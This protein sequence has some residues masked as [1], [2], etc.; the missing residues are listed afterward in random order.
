MVQLLALSTPSRLASPLHNNRLLNMEAIEVV[1]SV[2]AGQQQIVSHDGT[3]QYQATSDSTSVGTSACGL[4]ALNCARKLFGLSQDPHNDSCT[5]KT[6]L[7][8]V[9]DKDRCFLYRFLSRQ[10]IEVSWIYYY[11]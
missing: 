4:A 11:H 2:L 3:G 7:N 9:H 8:V 10:A 6:E 1:G 5:D